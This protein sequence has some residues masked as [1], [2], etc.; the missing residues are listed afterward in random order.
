LRFYLTG[1]KQKIEIK[2]SNLTQSTYSDWG[3]IKHGVPHGSILGSLLF[4][5]YIND[6]PH[7]PNTS[8]IPII[9][10]DDTIMIISSKY[11]ND[12]CILSIKFPS[13]MSKLFSAN[14]LCLTL[15]KT[16]VI[17]FITKN[18]PQY[19]LNTDYNDKYCHM[20]ECDCKRDLDW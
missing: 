3:R 11:S 7:T 13:Q 5:I 16:N 14:K 15:G 10:A 4:I 12:F 20:L 19:P 18:S 1:R 2:L 9:F 6:L 8:S 17:R